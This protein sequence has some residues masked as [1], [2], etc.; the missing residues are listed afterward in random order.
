[1]GVRRGKQNA[2][3]VAGCWNEVPEN[4]SKD[5]TGGGKRDRPKMA[6][7][8]FLLISARIAAREREPVQSTQE[9][10]QCSSCMGKISRRSSL[11]A[12][13]VFQVDGPPNP[14]FFFLDSAP[15]L[16]FLSVCVLQVGYK[17]KTLGIPQNVHLHPLRPREARPTFSTPL[18]PFS[19][20]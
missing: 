15:A 1:L 13:Q 5:G 8:L 17:D 11:K 16:F 6:R 19:F 4:L 7:E 12:R 3:S 10:A 20:S 9:S 14:G 18:F 2:W